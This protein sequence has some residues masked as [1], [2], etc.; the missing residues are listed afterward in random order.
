MDSTQNKATI[1]AIG[2]ELTTG[3]VT[4]RNA[5]W[6]S[7]KLTHFGMDVVLHATVADDRVAI[8]NALD[9]CAQLG[10]FLFVTGG[11]GP[12][13]DDFTREV[14]AEWL[15]QSLEFHD[16]VWQQ[17]QDRLQRLGVPIASSNRQQC[18]FP[19]GSQILKNNNGTAPGFTSPLSEINGSE[20]NGRIWVFPGPPAELS[21]VW[22]DNV[23]KMLKEA[24]P[25]IRPLRLFTWQCMRKS[26]AELGEITETT[27]AGSGLQTG[28]RAHRPFVEVKV[29]CPEHA[30]EEKKI[31]IQKLEQA[32]KPWIMTRQ[33]EDLA[34]T[35]LK[36]IQ[37][38]ES[39]ELIDSASGGLIQQR[40]SKLLIS[41][42]YSTQAETITLI[43]EWGPHEDPH[44][45]VTEILEHADEESMTLVLAGITPGGQG[46]I[47]LREHNRI[48]Q[49]EFQSMY[50]KPEWIDRMRSEMTEIALKCWCDWLD[51]ST[52]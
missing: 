41:P 11:L 3:Q 51:I 49:Q 35:L 14:I 46:S 48:Y 27:L 19:V 33:G 40:L 44:S 22:E 4:N 16:G 8:R 25:D 7:E 43:T 18:Y 36:K 38:A 32:L 17:V 23:E 9:H 20:T 15:G 39:A 12:T 2:T 28:Y 37:R 26:E 29:W 21:A 24:A 5:A 42:L 13:T 31:W 52:N 50:K 10:R 34:A 45:W 47:G 1:L 30:I 6:I